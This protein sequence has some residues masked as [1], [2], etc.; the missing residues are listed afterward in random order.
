MVYVQENGQ[1]QFAS[2][3]TRLMIRSYLYVAKI[4]QI[5]NYQTK[6]KDKWNELYK[7]YLY[8]IFIL[9]QLLFSYFF[10]TQIITHLVPIALF[11]IQLFYSNS[12]LYSKEQNQLQK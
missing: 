10:S 7:D 4:Y 3:R 5:I 9:I 1:I 2:T 6:Y 8:L 12:I 11:F